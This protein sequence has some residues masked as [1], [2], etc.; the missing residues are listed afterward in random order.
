MRRLELMNRVRPKLVAA[1]LGISTEV[2]TLTPF[3]I[4]R[5]Y[6]AS[7]EACAPL[8]IFQVPAA[9]LAVL[10]IPFETAANAHWLEPIEVYVVPA[11]QAAF[12]GYVW[13][14]F[15]ARSKRRNG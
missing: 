5:H 6:N 10:L 14:R 7:A 15:L 8:A 11:L 13:S 4:A 2:L 3:A 12:L 9:F 1:L